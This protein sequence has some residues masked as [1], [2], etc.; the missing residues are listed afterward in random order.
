MFSFEHDI[1]IGRISVIMPCYNAETFLEESIESVLNQTYIDVE[2]LVVDDGSTDGS[3]N[4]LANYAS[5]F[6][7]RISVIHQSNRGPYP[8]RNFA[9]QKAK[10]EFIA[11]LD[12]D[13]YWSVHCLEKLHAQLIETAS[14]ISYCGWQNIGKVGA[15]GQPYISPRYEEGNLVE[16]FL[17]ACPWPIHAALVRRY[18]VDRLN[19]FSTH[20]SSSLDYDFWL[21]SLKVTT[22]ITQVPVVLAFYRWHKKGQISSTVWIQ[23]INSWHVRKDFVE[24]NPN[25]VG[26]I[27]SKKIKEL[28]DGYL[29]TKAYS[30]FWQ[31]DLKSAQ[32]LFR[33]VFSTYYWKRGDLKYL[34]PSLLPLH[35]YTKIVQSFEGKQ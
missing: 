19:G 16:R 31:R 26:D 21:R 34:L 11:F 32:K 1:T 18:V 33:K 30:T 8:A 7:E 5:L 25:L 23:V 3:R 20:Y 27:P 10:G 24:K 22:K 35:F 29:L 9:L 15:A 12:A 13:D 4:I 28:I 2:L 14:D 6:P 17:K